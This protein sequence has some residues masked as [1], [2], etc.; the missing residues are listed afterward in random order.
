MEMTLGLIAGLAIFGGIGKRKLQIFFA[1]GIIIWISTSLSNSRGGIFATVC[2]IMLGFLLAI[3]GKRIS[4]GRGPF[5]RL[6]RF[7]SGSFTVRAS[8]LVAILI[9]VVAGTIWV[10]GDQLKLGVSMIPT[11]IGGD[12]EEL[13]IRR[14][15]IWK[16]GWR[17]FAAHPIV[18]S[19]FGAFSAAATKYHEKAG[20]STVRQAHND[21]LEILTSGGLIGA[22]L[23]LWFVFRFSRFVAGRMRRDSGFVLAAHWGAIIGLFG[24]AIHSF[25]EF[26]LHVPGNSVVFMALLAIAMVDVGRKAA[27]ENAGRS[28]W[29]EA[30]SWS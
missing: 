16:A 30:Q 19:G 5:E 9:V 8:A 1:C 27:E 13:S 26:G 28:S 6:L 3:S 7:A 10:G 22:A 29:A 4:V 15:D 18:G 17:S 25:V 24:V 20:V 21:Y 11:E 12:A 2:Q 14:A 23:G